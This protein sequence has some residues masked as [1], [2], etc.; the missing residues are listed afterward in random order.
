MHKGR[1]YPYHPSYW[2]TEGWFYRGFM[3]WRMK[4]TVTSAMVN[5]WDCLPIG[6]T[7]ISDPG[8]PSL[9]SKVIYYDW[10]EIG[11]FFPVNFRLTAKKETLAG[12]DI[13]SW[14]GDMRFHDGQHVAGFESQ[15]YP[16]RVVYLNFMRIVVP[17]PVTDFGSNICMMFEPASYEEGGSPWD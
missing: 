14:R 6:Y 4:L 5:P 7:A 12:S 1:P 15:V 17:V 9:D 8:V 10:I 13:C 3:P 11:L 2:A 16:Q